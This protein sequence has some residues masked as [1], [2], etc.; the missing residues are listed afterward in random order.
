MFPVSP[1]AQELLEALITTGQTYIFLVLNQ[2]SSDIN[3]IE[4]ISFSYLFLLLLQV[5]KELSCF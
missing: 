1:H 5:M 2:F 3:I 4:K